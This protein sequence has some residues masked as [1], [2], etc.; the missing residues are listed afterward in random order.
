VRSGCLASAS[1]GRFT[2]RNASIDQAALRRGPYFL[3]VAP[4]SSPR[5][6]DLACELALRVLLGGFARF[7][8]L[9]CL[10]ATQAPQRVDRRQVLGAWANLAL[11]PVVDGLGGCADQETAFGR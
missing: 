4:P 11:F 5:S 6:I 1:I 8:D 2:S 3:D 7:H 9:V 10:P